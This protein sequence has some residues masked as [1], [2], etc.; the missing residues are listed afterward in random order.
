MLLAACV[1]LMTYNVEYSNP[2]RAASIDAI[3]KANTDVVLLQEVTASWQREVVARLGTKYPHRAFHL[4]DR[5]AG[6]LA[7]LSKFPIESQQILPTPLRGWFPAGRFVLATPRGP[8]QILN[9]HLRPA[10]DNGWVRGFMTT[11]PLRRQ[12]IEAYWPAMAKLPTVVAGDFNEDPDGLAV[13]FLESKG[14]SRAVTTG[15]TTWRYERV[16][17]GKTYELL[18][19]NIDHVMTDKRLTARD[20]HVIDVGTSD[21]RPVVVTIDKR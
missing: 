13:Q 9:V 15:P 5:A 11:P 16:E 17:D 2:D 1:T 14:L 12:E 19:M 6:G 8:L 10:W 18:K 4:G 20:A 21:H 7:V 3:D